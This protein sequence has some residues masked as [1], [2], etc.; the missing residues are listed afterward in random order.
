MLPL[1]GKTKRNDTFSK[2]IPIDIPW[3][4]NWSD[5]RIRILLFCRV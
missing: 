5:C 4:I 1:L 2:K 3:G